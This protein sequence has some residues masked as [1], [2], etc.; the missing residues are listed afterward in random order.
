METSGLLPTPTAR[1]WKGAVGPNRHSPSIADMLALSVP[2][3]L[4]KRLPKQAEDKAKQMTVGSGL[5]LLTSYETSG[6]HSAF[7][8]MFLDSLVLNPVWYS[9]NCALNWKISVTPFK[10]TLFRLLPSTRH[11]D[12]IES[13]LLRTPLVHDPGTKV[14]MLV[15]KDGQPYRIGQ[16]GYNRLTGRYARVGLKQQLGSETGGRLQLQPAFVLWMMGIPETWL[17]FP[18]ERVS[19]KPGG[20]KKR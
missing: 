14:E 1:D 19:V 4:V 10:R 16:T 15:G 8:K 13:G 9:R 12:G 5:R 2:V 7:W 20:G 11:I 18:M 17:S 6:R 3:H